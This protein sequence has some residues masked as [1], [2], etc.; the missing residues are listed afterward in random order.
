MSVAGTRELLLDGTFLPT[1]RKPELAA[2]HNK[3]ASQR[4]EQRPKGLIGETR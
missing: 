3:V 2:G 1:R 4:L